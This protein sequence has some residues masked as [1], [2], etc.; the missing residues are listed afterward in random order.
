[1]I[2]R[3]LTWSANAAASGVLG[4]LVLMAAFEGAFWV[5]AWLQHRKRGEG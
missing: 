1:M 4:W 3:G 2:R 5:D